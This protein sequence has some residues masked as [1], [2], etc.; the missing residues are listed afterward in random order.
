MTWVDALSGG[1]LRSRLVQHWG[2]ITDEEVQHL[3][4]HRDDAE[5]VRVLQLA[6]D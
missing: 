1:E 3:I 5:V 4:A 6:L 2:D